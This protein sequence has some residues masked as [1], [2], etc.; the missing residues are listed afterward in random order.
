MLHC[1]VQNSPKVSSIL[2]LSFQN[3][4]KVG[5]ILHSSNKSCH[6]W[7]SH[8]TQEID[9]SLSFVPCHWY[10]RHVKSFQN[11]QKVGSILH[12]AAHGS[13]QRSLLSITLGI[14]TNESQSHWRECILFY[15]T[16]IERTSPPRGGFLST[17]F[18]HQ[19]PGGRGPPS[20]H[21]VQILRR[22]SFS[23]GFLIRE[24][25]K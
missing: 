15:Y 5:S 20:K 11:S 18:P 9:M 2:L 12:W 23:S 8:V 1:S 25:G 13:K 14:L 10:M 24:D 17:M 7:M 22:G 6:M 21:L 16:L 3:S 19:A 4:R